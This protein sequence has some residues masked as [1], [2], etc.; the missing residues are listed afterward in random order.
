MRRIMFVLALGACAGCGAVVEPGHRALLFDSHNKG[1]RPEVLGPGHYSLGTHGRLEDFDVTFS[2]RKEELNTSS[3]EGLAVK[4][5]IAVI[6]RPIIAELYELDN[7]IGR[8]YYDEVVGPEFRSAARGVFAQHSYADLH[9]QNEKIEDEIEA[10]L[11]RRTNGK[12][13]E[14]ASVVIESIEYAPEVWNAHHVRLLADLEAARQRG[15]LENEAVKE[16]L[17]IRL[18][19]EQERERLESEAARE[20]FAAAL[21]ARRAAPP[22]PEARGV[23]GAPAAQRAPSP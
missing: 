22:I 14:V 7:E 3:S 2:T 10:H 16:K 4:T 17:V 21:R 6:Y 19:A 9:R 23:A 18:R 20:E 11:R 12:H 1:L 8:N 5:V 15:A 13:V